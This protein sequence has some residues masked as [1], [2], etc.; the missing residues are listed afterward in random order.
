MLHQG[1]SV[2]RL[3]GTA[4]EFCSKAA[5]NARFLAAV[6]SDPPHA[7]DEIVEA[8]E[9]LSTFAER[10]EYWFHSFKSFA[11]LEN[12]FFKAKTDNPY[13]KYQ[14]TEM[15]YFDK[16]TKT[17]S[18]SWSRREDLCFI[19]QCF[20]CRSFILQFCP[21]TNLWCES[22]LT[23]CFP[24]LRYSCSNQ[25]WVEPV[26]RFENTRFTKLRGEDTHAWWFF[27]RRV[28]VD[29]SEWICIL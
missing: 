20:K 21:S 28:G 22:I 16:I 26:T 29:W 7:V 19:S 8:S 18:H 13:F 27:I 1:S 15:M 14:R 12:P 17:A 3:L 23:A 25:K 5:K 2:G 4:S 9:L 11:A 10:Y 6:S 24:L